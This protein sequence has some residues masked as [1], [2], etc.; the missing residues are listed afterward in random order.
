M[1]KISVV[2]IAKN[3]EKEIAACLKSVK[4]ADEIIVLD[5]GSVDGTVKIANDHRA[6]V[7]FYKWNDDFAEARNRALDYATNPWVLS[8]D[9]DEEL[10]G[11]IEGLRAAIDANFSK[12]CIA[13]KV[14]DSVKEY[15]VGRIFRKTGAYWI[16]KIHEDLNVQPVDFT[17]KVWLKHNPSKNHEVDPD[18]NIRILKDVLHHSPL[19]VRDMFYLGE[20]YFRAE[21]YEGAVY[22]LTYYVQS[23]PKTPTY[24]AEAY[25]ILCESYCKLNRPNRGVEALHSAIDANPEMKSAYERL[26]QLTK[27]EKWTVLAEGATNKNTLVIR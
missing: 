17:D 24:T 26:A 9:T 23:S 5:T 13:L 12:N 20:E 8:I 19:S 22:W 14:K 25:F 18:R 1:S 16:G 10:I 27:N 11:G 15:W 2:I 3:N 4:G 6:K 7:F 21:N